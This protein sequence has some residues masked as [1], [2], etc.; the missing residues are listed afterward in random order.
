MQPT[1]LEMA[2]KRVIPSQCAHWRG[3][4]FPKQFVWEFDSKRWVLKMRI[5]T[6][7]TALAMT[8]KS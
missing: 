5:A 8:K 3:N 1:F 2:K 6:G 7:L 4:P